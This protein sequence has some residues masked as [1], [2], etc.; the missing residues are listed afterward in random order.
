MQFLVLKTDYVKPY[1]KTKTLEI[2]A[3]SS[4]TT[5]NNYL[6]FKNSGFVDP[7]RSVDFEYK[8]NINAG[9]I[10]FKQQLNDKWELIT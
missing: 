1:G 5:I 4:F 6:T 2:V 10:N 3:K 7:K 8:E 9:Y